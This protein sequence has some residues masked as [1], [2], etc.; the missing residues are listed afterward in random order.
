MNVVIDTSPLSSN[1]SGRGI[2]VYTKHLIDALQTYESKHSYILSDS[3]KIDYKKA[4][5]IHYPYFDPFFL[6][7]PLR[8]PK[9]SVVTVHDLI[10]L[11]FPKHF[12]KG[13]RGALKWEIQKMALRTKERI[14]TDSECS[15]AD[16]AR[17]TG[18]KKDRID[19]TLLAPSLYPSKELGKERIRIEGLQT[20]YFLYVG[21]V[22]WNK[23]VPGLLA[24][25]ASFHAT[26]TPIQLILV[27]KAFC[28]EFLTES[29]NIQAI[30]TDLGIQ[31]SVLRPGYVSDDVLRTLYAHAIA[32]IQPSYY[33]GFGFP[34]LDAMNLGCPVITSQASSLKEI[35]G[36][37]RAID[38]QDMQ[39]FVKA[40]DDIYTM[41]K[42][43]RVD[44]IEKGYAWVKKFTWQ[45]TAKHTVE[46]YE[47]VLGKK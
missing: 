19:V 8:S 43:E 9:P 16:I 29:H 36:P 6:T 37:S 2:G 22:N 25:F 44:L 38:P 40:M 21:D 31:K 27:G 3:K 34:V 32:L 10:P 39:S 15:K 7:L 4:D 12:P 47:K 11:V 35:L 33:E 24:A 26:H 14:L 46:A 41:E 13:I 20:Q 5:I 1:H 42:E 28:D 18:I 17:I 23:N 30:I 45:E